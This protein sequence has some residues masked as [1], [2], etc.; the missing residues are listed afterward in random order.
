MKCLLCSLKFD[1]SLQLEHHYLNF[2]KV[3]P[4]NKFYQNLIG[5]LNKK[6]K[7]LFKK[8]LRCSEILESTKIKTI[9]EFAS[10]YSDGEQ[11]LPENKPINIEENKLFTKY[12][13]DIKNFGNFYDFYNSEK[14]ISDFLNNVKTRFQIENDHVIIK[15]SC[16]IENIQHSILDDIPPLKDTRYWST[17]AYTVNY[18]NQF[19]YYNL[20]EDYSKRV[21]NNGLTGSSWVFNRFINLSLTVLKNQK[22]LI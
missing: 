19:V 16:V 4:N 14:V 8:C 7:F 1:T 20:A 9:H 11:E 17:D 18:F 22:L 5:H 13:I 21:I 10:H 12:S 6:D 2:H 15:G 3:N